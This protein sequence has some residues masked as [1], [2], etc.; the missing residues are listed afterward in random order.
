MPLWIVCL[1]LFLG[2]SS[3][4]TVKREQLTSLLE[5]LRGLGNTELPHN[6]LRKVTITHDADGDDD[7]TYE[8]FDINILEPESTRTINR[9]CKTRTNVLD[10]G[11]EQ[12][13]KEAGT[14][15]KGINLDPDDDEADMDKTIGL[16]KVI[17]PSSQ[18]PSWTSRTQGSLE[19]A[20]AA[21]A[22]APTSPRPSNGLMMPS[23]KPRIT[24]GSGIQRGQTGR[25]RLGAEAITAL[26]KEAVVEDGTG[27]GEGRTIGSLED[28]WSS[29]AATT[30]LDSSTAEVPRVEDSAAYR[31]DGQAA[32]RKEE[33][34]GGDG[35]FESVAAAA[36]STAVYPQGHKYAASRRTGPAASLAA[37]RK[38]LSRLEAFTEDGESHLEAVV[39]AAAASVAALLNSSTEDDSTVIRSADQTV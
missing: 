18:I 21:F 29:S 32:G 24:P 8:K 10:K 16:G 35:G 22:T 3:P 2:L 38:E 36:A 6:N 23:W 20:I 12:K 33:T 19:T 37:K 17:A 7:G 25:T 30:R 1:L 26:K 15:K 11:E 13:E 31:R 28:I 27:A 9:T 39:A 14:S 4:L 34:E 5:H